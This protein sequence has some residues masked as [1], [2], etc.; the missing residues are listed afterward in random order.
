MNKIKASAVAVMASAMIVAPVAAGSPGQLQGGSN[1]YVVKNVTQ[2]GSYANSVNTVKCG[3]TV[4]YSIQLAN[5]G[6]GRLTDIKVNA[7]LGITSNMTAIPAEGSVAGTSAAVTVVLASGQTL[8]YDKDSTILY[9][10]HGAVV[11][12]L[13]NGITAGGINVGNLAGSTNEFV[14]FTAHVNC[15]ETPKTPETPATPSTP[16][17][18]PTAL[19]DT[20]A[21]GALA[22]VAGTG[23]L[24]YAVMQYRRSRKALAD[25]L[26]NRK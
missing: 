15:P 18:T 5:T 21:E 13:P 2:G 24:G 12:T 6:F 9:D 25:V 23:A 16:S 8:N 4:K 10:T 17:V 19:P 22:G 7:S 1:T 3:D 20:G 11:K 26:R 14:N